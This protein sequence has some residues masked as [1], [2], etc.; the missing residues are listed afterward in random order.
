VDEHITR[1][2]SALSLVHTKL[3]TDQHNQRLR[4][5]MQGSKG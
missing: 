2:Q 1:A 4:A 5:H 3:L